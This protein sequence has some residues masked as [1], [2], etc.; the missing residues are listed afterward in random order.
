MVCSIVI[1]GTDKD[2][3]VSVWNIADYVLETE[4]YINEK[5]LY[6]EVGFNEKIL[7]VL[8]KKSNKIFN[9]IC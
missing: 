2:S 3:A 7:K 8:V 1:K 6:K 4:K 9:L 5:Q